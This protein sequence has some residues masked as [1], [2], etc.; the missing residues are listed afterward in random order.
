VT[1]S[2]QQLRDAYLSPQMECY[3]ERKL[4]DVSAAEVG[5]RIEE[6]LK[7]LNMA[8]YCHGNIPV[9][10][11]IDDIWHYWILET[12]EYQKLCASLQGGRF[13][14]H[15]SNVYAECSGEG[16]GAP[17]ND[18]EQ[19]VAMLGNYVLNYGPFEEDRVKYWLLAAHLVDNCGLS[20]DQV[21][22]WLTSGTA[23]ATTR[24][25]GAAREPRAIRL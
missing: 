12:N 16:N 20:V 4:S 25:F 22:D 5:V 18:L 3:F 23:S 15:S 14:H 24:T 2:N 21:N 1:I 13:I 9:S 19:D 7:F 8:T 10:Q 11:E 17:K 6:T